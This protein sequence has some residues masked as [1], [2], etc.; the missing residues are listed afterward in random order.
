MGAL[1][2]VDSYSIYISESSSYNWLV[3]FLLLQTWLFMYWS[4]T[5]TYCTVT[6]TFLSSTPSGFFSLCFSCKF[7][8]SR[9]CHCADK[10]MYTPTKAKEDQGMSALN[11]FKPTQHLPI[12]TCT[13]K[14]THYSNAPSGGSSLN[15]LFP[16]FFILGN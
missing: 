16:S 9:F 8:H 10:A 12:H 4:T 1:H 3:W 15:I 6:C 7:P 14:I 2:L 13:H 5:S 11:S